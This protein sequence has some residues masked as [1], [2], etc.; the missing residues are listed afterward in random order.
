MRKMMR[1]NLVSRV[2]AA[3]S[4][5]FSCG[6]TLPSRGCFLSRLHGHI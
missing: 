6:L 4:S 1:K 5:G 3:V 2:A